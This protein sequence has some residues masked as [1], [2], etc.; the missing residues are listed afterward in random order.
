M[1][2]VIAATVIFVGCNKEDIMIPQSENSVEKVV[3]TNKNQQDGV[4]ARYGSYVFYRGHKNDKIVRDPGYV[5]EWKITD[6]TD[7]LRYPC[8]KFYGPD[9]SVSYI[10]MTKIGNQWILR[11]SLQKY[12]RYYWRYV[13]SYGGSNL[14]SW[15]AHIDNIPVPKGG[16][17]YPYAAG[18][19]IPDT[20][21]CYDKWRFYRYNCTSWVSWK[22]NQ[23]WG[24][25]RAFTNH[26]TSPRLSH[27]VS[28]KRRLMSLGYDANNTP[29]VGSIA[30][31]SSHPADSRY[32]HVAFVVG[33]QSNGAVDIQEYNYLPYRYGERTLQPGDL[34]YP[35]S[36][37]HVQHKR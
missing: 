34:W 11:K 28:W 22:V 2:V 14:T 26:M 9:H 3:E 17:D 19:C 6:Y 31:W 18:E 1:A 16:D 32:G 25:S 30:Y 27:A 24:T 23:M 7:R 8:V 5:Y 15:N 12:G 21:G 13:D 36:F 4:S 10:A 20:K 33:V 37:I 29:I 35:Q